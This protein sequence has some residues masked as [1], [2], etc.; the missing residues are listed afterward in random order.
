[1][2]ILINIEP[3]SIHDV[4][5][6]S[7]FVYKELYSRL[8]FLSESFDVKFLISERIFFQ[9]KEEN[10]KLPENFICIPDSDYRKS[11]ENEFIS[12]LDI[13]KQLYFGVFTNK[14]VLNL[15]EMYGKHFQDWVP[16]IIISYEL[17]NK[18]FDYVFQNAVKLT[19]TGGFFKREILPL[20]LVFD[21]TGCVGQ[22]FFCRFSENFKSLKLTDENNSK[23]IKLKN[24]FQNIIS[25]NNPLKTIMS[26]YRKKFDY[27]ILLPL[28]ISNHFGF[29]CEC[30]FKTQWDVV[31]YVLD[32][33]PDNVGVIVTE[34]SHSK[35]L[36][37]GRFVK[38]G[39]YNWIKNKY[40]NFI[41]IQ[42]EQENWQA[43]SLYIIPE[44]DAVINV[45][46][47]VGM[48]ALMF[49]KKII[50]LAHNFND[51]F[52]DAQG[53]DNIA[54]V[55][56][57]PQVIDKNPFLYW[58]LTR[59]T[60]LMPKLEDKEF[61]KSFFE[62]SFVKY[63]KGKVDFDFYDEIMSID[64]ISEYIMN[65]IENNYKSITLSNKK[66]SEENIEITKIAVNN[67]DKISFLQKIFSVKNEFN[68]KVIRL[69]GI[70]IKIRKEKS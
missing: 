56:K 67:A 54:D 63:T 35:F 10:Y 47:T 37:E 66:E 70:R 49:D 18:A 7:I 53:L 3:A 55:L 50:S 65:T 9:A 41:Y 46:S 69:F 25:A 43:S 20:S 30:D 16:D 32:N 57:N 24:E 11:F 12:H 44:V 6:P 68:H 39:F 27:L 62:K 31:T 17:Y 52:K 5:V 14:I 1:M 22:S 15:K 51:A 19:Y 38:D 42:P 64:E 4:F 2:K 40:K 48:L 33:I 26:E 61:M 58:L 29:D 59:Y 13:V 34:H 60:F 8:S 23:I 28:Q 45:S 36:R 21:V